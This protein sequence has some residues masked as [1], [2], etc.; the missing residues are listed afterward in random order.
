MQSHSWVLG[1]LTSSR[2]ARHAPLEP[3]SARTLGRER[4]HT[5]GKKGSWRAA[6][7]EQSQ[8]H[9]SAWKTTFEEL[10]PEP[11]LSLTFSASW[12]VDPDFT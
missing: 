3:H 10:K 9:G 11:D 12:R 8:N 7:L 5:G 2:V 6:T 1:W 4:I